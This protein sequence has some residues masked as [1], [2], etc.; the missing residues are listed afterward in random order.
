MRP[1]KPLSTTSVVVLQKILTTRTSDSILCTFNVLWEVGVLVDD[2]REALNNRRIL[3]F[4]GATGT[5]LAARASQPGSMA[6]LLSPDIVYEVH[7]A[8]R[9]AGADILLTN[10]LTAN[11]IYLKHAGQEDKFE[12]LN[13]AAVELCRK[14]A[15]DECYVCGDMGPTGQFL[16]PYGEYTEQQF[17]EN[18]SEQA[19]LLMEAGADFIIIETMTCVREAAISAQA[20]K[21]ATGLPVIA[22]V[23]FD[24]AGG[25]FRTMMGDTVEKAVQELSNAGVDVIG[26]NCGTVDPVEISEIVA[27]MRALTDLPLAAEPNAGK[28]ELTKGQVVFSLDPER[29]A[30]GVL[31]CVEAGATLVGGCCG[32][33]PD[34]IR[35]LVARL[36]RRQ[37]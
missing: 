5:Q 32:T 1:T 18:A 2:F 25:G 13:R 34:H 19:R 12:E 4:D 37:S 7:V 15:G 10:T 30:E 35:S 22:C 21:E 33:T 17:Y 36:T 29:F 28:P 8:Y 16:E 20:A 14:A 23:S 11:R 27:R 3:V 9:E 6:T 31:K 26:T 24:A